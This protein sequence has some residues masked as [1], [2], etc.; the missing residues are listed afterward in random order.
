MVGARRSGYLATFVDRKSGYLAAAV[1]SKADFGKV[2]FAK[3]AK[4]ALGNLPAEYLR[5]LTL[6]KRSGDEAAGEDRAPDGT[7]RLLR[8]ALPQLGERL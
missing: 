3:A 8:Y 1:L 7:G 4:K 5:T 2:G 6:D